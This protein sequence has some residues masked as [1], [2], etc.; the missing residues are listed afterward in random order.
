MGARRQRFRVGDWLAG[1]DDNDELIGRSGFDRLFGGGGDDILD[2]GDDG[3]RDILHG[4]TGGDTFVR[5]KHVFNDDPDL[6]LGLGD[7]AG[8]RQFNDWVWAD[9]GNDFPEESDFF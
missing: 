2:G 8:D 3:I 9:Y 4:G 5:H 7:D 1:G 6:F